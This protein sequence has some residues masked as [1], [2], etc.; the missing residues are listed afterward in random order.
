MDIS[1]TANTISSG[2]EGIA[3]VYVYV[4]RF[5]SKYFF[6]VKQIGI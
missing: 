6:E 1:K 5:L 4:S 3:K 2:T